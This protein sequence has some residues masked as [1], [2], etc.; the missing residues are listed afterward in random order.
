MYHTHIYCL[1]CLSTESVGVFDTQALL[2]GLIQVTQELGV[3]YLNAE[4]IGYEMEIQR[5][6]LMEGVTPGS[7]E[8]IK[9]LLYKNKEGEEIALKFATCVIAGGSESPHIAKLAKIGSGDGLLTIP[10]PIE[11][12]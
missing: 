1:G 8:K 3:I 7:F 9:N 2:K 10:L 6:L 4:V 12:R 11:K 5:D